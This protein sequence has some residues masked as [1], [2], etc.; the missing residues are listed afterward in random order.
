MFERDSISLQPKDSREKYI[1]LFTVFLVASK[2]LHPLFF[3]VLIENNDKKSKHQ[4]DHTQSETASP[5][6]VVGFM[7][8]VTFG[9]TETESESEQPVVP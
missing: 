5:L 2:V 6:V 9:E 7:T 1:F 8:T 3:C 4:M